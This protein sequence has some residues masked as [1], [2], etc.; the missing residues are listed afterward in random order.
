MILKLN[1]LEFEQIFTYDE[2]EIALPWSRFDF[3]IVIGAY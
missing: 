3:I 2:I 1:A